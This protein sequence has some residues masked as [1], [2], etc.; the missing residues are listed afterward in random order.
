MSQDDL[1]TAIVVLICSGSLF[2]FGAWVLRR[3][4]YTSLK[5]GRLHRYTREEEP[6]SFWQVVI[7][8]WV[9]AACILFIA[10]LQ[11]VRHQR[12][13]LAHATHSPLHVQSI[14][15]PVVAWLFAITLISVSI[16]VAKRRAD[17]KGNGDD[18]SDERE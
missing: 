18:G 12:S 14:V 9:I 3:G 13:G 7:G 5:H 15:I 2:A 8:A 1:A 16:W 17:A 11:I 6:V 10:V 4:S